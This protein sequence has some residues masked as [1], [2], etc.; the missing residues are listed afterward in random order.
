MNQRR[1]VIA[2][3]AIDFVNGLLK[4]TITEGHNIT[5]LPHIHLQRQQ[6]DDGNNTLDDHHTH[7][8]CHPMSAKL[9]P[10]SLS[11]IRIPYSERYYLVLHHG[12]ILTICSIKSE[13]ISLTSNN[14]WLLVKL[15]YNGRFLRSLSDDLS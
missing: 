11:R 2:L 12:S 4:D 3:T 5:A 10:P 9:T 7:C 8:V 15:S 1:N 6:F 14:L 13:P